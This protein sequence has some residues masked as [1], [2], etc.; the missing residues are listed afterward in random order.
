MTLATV[1]GT[2]ITK[3]ITK[4]SY[5]VNSEPVYESWQNANFV[6]QH[7]FVRSRIKG[8]FEVRCGNGLSLSTFIGLFDPTTHPIKTTMG[9][10]VQNENRLASSVNVFYSIEG[11]E[12]VELQNGI[13]YDRLIVKIEEC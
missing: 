3:Y 4:D 1:N 7:I 11:Q 5:K 8:Q 9:L 2:D 10:F 6:T 12:H 13:Y